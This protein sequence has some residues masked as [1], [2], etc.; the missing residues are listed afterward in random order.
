MKKSYLL[1]LALLAGGLSQAQYSTN[2]DG[3]NAGDYIGVKD[4]NWTT[5]NGSPGTTE[6]AQINTAQAQSGANSIYFASTAA[7]GGPQDVVLEFGAAHNTGL[8]EFEQSIFVTTN[9]AA[10][11]NFQAET[12]PGTTWALDVN[13][14]QDGTM[15]VAYQG[16]EVV[17]TPF[18]AN[19][20]VAFKLVVNL[21]TNIWEVFLD[22]VS[23]GEFQNDENQIASLDIYPTNNSIPS[24]NN[25]SEFWIDDVSF[26]H[27]PYT[28]PSK[29]GA[30]YRIDFPGVALDGKTS[31]PSVMVRNL[32][33][34]TIN[35]FDLTLDYNGNQI[36]Q[37]VF[38]LNL[39]SLATYAVEL[40]PGVL[41]SAAS[42]SVSAT[43]SNVNGSNADDDPTDDTK[44]V[45]FKP[46]VPA[47]G[48]LVIVEEATGT[49]CGWCPRGTVALQFLDRDYHG[50]AQ[51]IAVHN[52][53]PM[54]NSVYD[55]GIGTKI[56]GY[57]S[58]LV[59]RGADLDPSAIW[60]EI[61]TDLA[62]A[63]TA[64]LYN[65]AQYDASRDLVEVALVVDFQAPA[66]DNW[67]V[68][69][70]LIE[71]SVTGTASGYAQVN[72]YNTGGPLVGPDNIDWSSLPNPVPANMSVYNHVARA[73]SP[74]FEG[75]ANVFPATVNAN[76]RFTFNFNFTIDPS[77]DVSKMHVVGMLIKE[78]GSIDNG[79]STTI[80]Q[81][82][83]NGFWVGNL[84]SITEELLGPDAK[85]RIYPNPVEAGLTN[86]SFEDAKGN[87]S[88]EIVDVTGKV[89]YEEMISSKTTRMVNLNTSKWSKGTYLVHVKSQ[90]VNESHRLVVR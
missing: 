87:V 76:D 34:Q 33:S 14:F 86:I 39:A 70:V 27:T 40:T 42:T 89:V 68:A 51:G 31:I 45:N 59:D 78:D 80:N 13:F 74:S 66:N 24:S 57:P 15:Q 55:A 18:T 26:T 63:P 7:N 47:P 9:K 35:S 54:V 8:F 84:V 4:A 3:L 20:W 10:Y 72:Y 69:C 65:G 36:T 44:T 17:N 52:G 61:H 50:F 73:I 30:V 75:Q 19:G 48:K 67:K 5:W 21:N 71:D 32:G 23:Q 83:A 1:A 64:L 2:F 77:W 12:T 22:G 46:L 81:A 28:L 25:Q 6:D 82:I 88:I 53:D 85:V 58:A 11:F 29:N 38:N 49:W 41:I 79:S 56:S 90:N 37:T 16:N 43:I 62:E 60:A